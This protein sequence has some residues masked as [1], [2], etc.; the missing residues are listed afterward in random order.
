[1]IK[2]YD[3]MLLPIVQ[4]VLGNLFEMAVEL[5]GIDI[6]VFVNRLLDFKYLF[7]LETADPTLVL[8][9]SANEILALILDEEPIEFESYPYATA[10]YWCGYVLAYAAWYFNKPYK[11]LL[12]SYPIDKLLNNYFPYHEM[13]IMHIINKIGECIPFESNLKKYRK[14][15]NLS[16]NELAIISNVSLRTIRAYEQGSIDIAKGSAEILYSLSR[17][18]DCKIE[19]LL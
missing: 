16:Q 15:N 4:D 3:E 12:E 1:M 10:E 6:N 8:G 19:D 14:L 17:A 2:A 18:L 7:K 5:K 9:K 11:Y 13:D